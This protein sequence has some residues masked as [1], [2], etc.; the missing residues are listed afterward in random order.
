[1]IMIALANGCHLT[2]RTDA[3]FNDLVESGDFSRIV[4][5]RVITLDS[6]WPISRQ[7]LSVYQK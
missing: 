5:Q 4:E 1:M 3:L 7:L 2:R 6:H